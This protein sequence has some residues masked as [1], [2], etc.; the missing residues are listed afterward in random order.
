[1]SSLKNNKISAK[2]FF[3]KSYDI[4]RMI[5]KE[6]KGKVIKVERRKKK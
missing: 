2:E 4:I 6:F 3:G 1:M 5:I